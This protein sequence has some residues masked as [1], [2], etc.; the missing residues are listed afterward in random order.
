MCQR[1]DAGPK[2][3]RHS[4]L[5]PR[6]SSHSVPDVVVLEGDGGSP[7]KLEIL[8]VGDA[9]VV[10]AE[11]ICSPVNE[12]LIACL[13]LRDLTMLVVEQR[14]ELLVSLGGVFGK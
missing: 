12:V 2:L 10:F 9:S 11:G 13:V 3:R 1:I 7:R 8:T 6:D 14:A 5:E 4:A